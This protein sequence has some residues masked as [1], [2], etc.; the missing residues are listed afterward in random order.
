L[1]PGVH[2]ALRRIARRHDATLHELLVRELLLT[3]RDWNRLHDCVQAKDSFSVLVPTNVRNLEHDALPAANVLGYVS[4][5]RTL[6]DL[7]E[8]DALL[9]SIRSE[10]RFHRRWRFAVTF[11]NS[12]KVLA[13]IPG[14]TRYLLNREHCYA[15]S[16]LST[17]GDPSRIM[18]SRYPVNANGDPVMANLVLTDISSAP[19]I[20]PLT[21][22]S[23]TAWH[24]SDKQRLSVRCDP[25]FFNAEQTQRLL[26]LFAERVVA[27]AATAD[28]V[29]KPQRVAA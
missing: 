8:P 3:N 2:S 25:K 29:R 22:A 7:N 24:F 4:F 11:V 6:S 12:L 23:F 28:G 16:V 27:L 26:D 14:A 5:L 15:S 20:R 10:S 9:N 18:A 19:P 17:I 1:E 13:R 21:R